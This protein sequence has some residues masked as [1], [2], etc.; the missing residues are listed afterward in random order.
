MNHET[1]QLLTHLNT[2]E[3][4]LRTNL[5]MHFQ[6]E[7]ARH[8]MERAT[9]HVREALGFPRFSGHPGGWGI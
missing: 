4:A 3:D 7:T 1:K 2:A 5:H 9:S 8:H 6:D